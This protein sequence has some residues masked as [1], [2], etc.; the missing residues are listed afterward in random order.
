MTDL[1]QIALSAAVP[2]NI[3][4]I[5][6]KGGITD[7]DMKKCNDFSTVLGEKGDKILWPSNKKGET[8]KLFNE[9]VYCIAVM[10]F[11]PGRITILNQHYESKP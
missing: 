9:L 6:E 10:S 7:E 2:L 11:C 8:A 1:L 3:L 4:K 5:K